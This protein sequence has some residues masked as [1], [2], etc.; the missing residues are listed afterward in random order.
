M[1]A[2]QTIT[3]HDQLLDWLERDLLASEPKRPINSGIVEI[4][5][6]IL[7][8][9]RDVGRYRMHS[10]F[11]VEMLES[12]FLYVIDST[13]SPQ[14]PVGLIGFGATAW[15]EIIENGE[16][17]IEDVNRILIAILQYDKKLLRTR[18]VGKH[19]YLKST[20]ECVRRYGTEV[21]VKLRQ[22]ER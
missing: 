5:L 13:S 1:R 11:W 19:R 2:K 20:Q 16:I 22:P 8:E 10:G 18:Q 4:C 15:G 7:V 9:V 14:Y 17:T 3:T 12:I 6:D 21:R